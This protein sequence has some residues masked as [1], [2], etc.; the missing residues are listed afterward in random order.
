LAVER[1][2]CHDGINLPVVVRECIDFIEEHGLTV[3][4]IYRSSG[5]KSK[6][7]KLRAAYNTRHSV[8]LAGSEP[9][10]VAS[11]L[12]LFLRELPDPVLTHQL[13]SKFEEVS[14]LKDAN[15]I[16]TSLRSLLDQLP[17]CNRTLLQWIFV[18]MGHVIQHEKQNKM[19]L[20]NVSIV[21]SPTT[22]ISH[23][24]LYCLFKHSQ[25]LFGHVSIKKYVPPISG[26]SMVSLLP[27][28]P[29][30]IEEEMKKQES[31]LEDLHKQISL[32]MASKAT[33]EQLWEQQRIVTQLKRNLRL[34]KSSQK[35]EDN[36][37]DNEEELNFSLQTPADFSA[38]TDQC[39][40]D[41]P[42]TNSVD[43]GKNTC[44]YKEM[45]SPEDKGDNSGQEHRITVQIHQ[46]EGV[47]AENGHVTVIKLVEPPCAET[48][49]EENSNADSG[50]ADNTV[51]PGVTEGSDKDT[52]TQHPPQSI[53][54]HSAAKAVQNESEVLPDDVENVQLGNYAQMP[55]LIL[56]PEPLTTNKPEIKSNKKVD[57]KPEPIC[58]KSNETRVSCNP[59]EDVYD[60]NKLNKSS[61]GI[62]LLPPPPSSSKASSRG[63][64]KPTILPRQDARMKSKSLPRG[65][66]SDSANLNSQTVCN[67]I[68][69]DKSSEAAASER[70]Q[71][72]LE[73]LRLKFE[74]E[75]LKN[76]KSEL[77][78]RKK[79]ERREVN[80]LQEEIATMQTLYQYRTYSVD[81]SEDSDD[82]QEKQK[83]NKDNWILLRQLAREQSH[84]EQKK[85]LLLSKLENHRKICL[86][87]RVQIRLEQE[88]VKRRIV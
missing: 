18:H 51:S 49:H 9:A 70:E 5:V 3:E 28:S 64:L 60:D 78:R 71:L 33:E 27:Q 4:G 85:T 41:F 38:S 8:V 87:L 43:S 84:L 31:L 46:S 54:N 39:T 69:T 52:P 6:V 2:R 48:K 7:N 37:P 22:Q 44:I 20:Q 80:E 79:T 12:K 59:L 74:Y 34:A 17:D 30:G 76:L 81:S 26:Q 13:I 63:L 1:S 40:T 86:Q 50:L 56:K 15:T 62:P 14:A 47:E 42:M 83:V 23:R 77:E 32:G 57:F 29:Q 66:P 73:E 68:D 25:S 36:R 61:N 19:T 45:S 53:K 67:V 21:L 16:M 88:R 72:I 55:S 10:V 24:V 58:E 11:L 65:L 82:E 75:E 35:N